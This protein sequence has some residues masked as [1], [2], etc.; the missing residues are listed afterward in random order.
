MRR[1]YTYTIK[2]ADG[3]T[4]TVKTQAST[5]A[6][7]IRHAENGTYLIDGKM[8]KPIKSSFKWVE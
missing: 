7:A 2:A 5:K 1:I 4:R 3:E 6:E 8:W